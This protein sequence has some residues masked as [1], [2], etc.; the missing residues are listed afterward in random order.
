MK[1]SLTLSDSLHFLTYL[2]LCHLVI[3]DMMDYEMKGGDYDE[4]MEESMGGWK[5]GNMM[6]DVNALGYDEDERSGEWADESMPGKI[7]E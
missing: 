3:S 7:E 5:G 1:A 2:Y 6:M 4:S